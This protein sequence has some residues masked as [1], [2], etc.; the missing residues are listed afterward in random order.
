MQIT[1]ILPTINRK[2]Y[3]IRAI[4]S[5]LDISLFSKKIISKVIVYDGFSDDGAWEIMQ[6]KY[7]K[8]EN[9]TLKQVDRKL[10]FQETAFLALKDVET[11]YCTF[12]YNDDVISQYYYQMA[13]KMV[14][15]HQNFIMGYGKNMEVNKIYKFQKPN[16]KII[17]TKNIILNYFGLFNFLEYSSL[18]VSPVPSISKTKILRQWITEVRKF[19][20]NSKF[21]EELMIKKNIGPDLVIYLYNLIYENENLCICNSSIAQLSFHKSS[22]SI[23]YGKA[24]LSTGYWLSRIWCFEKYLTKNKCD[25]NFLSKLSS[26][27]II[28]GI[29]IFFTNLK[30]LKIN[31][32]FNVILETFA[33]IKKCLLE[34]IILK[35]LFNFPIILLN[36][37]KRD[38]KNY[39]PN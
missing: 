15:N 22:M 21:R 30:S 6:K 26:Y 16:F 8:N 14:K 27:I 37:L 1:F 10:G 31:Y 2:D 33:V 24:P 35:T 38:K 39:T 20:E 28:G 7:S 11:E 18:P 4:D 3:I 23:S 12:M 9:V 32:A 19:I 36:R 34:K 25:K 17:E 13:E 29:F 5:C